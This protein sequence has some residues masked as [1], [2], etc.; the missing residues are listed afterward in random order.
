MNCVRTT[1]HKYGKIKLGQ[2]ATPGSMQNKSKFKCKNKKHTKRNH[3]E[4]SLYQEQ[5]KILRFQNLEAMR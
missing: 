3:G 2:Y 1:R 4:I 5:K